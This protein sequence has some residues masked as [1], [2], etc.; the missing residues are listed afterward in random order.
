MDLEKDA[1]PE[2]GITNYPWMHLVLLPFVSTCLASENPVYRTRS[3]ILRS[4]NVTIVVDRS[5][6]TRKRYN[7]KS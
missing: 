3:H 4:V 2:R 6:Y 5:S 7:K 1:L